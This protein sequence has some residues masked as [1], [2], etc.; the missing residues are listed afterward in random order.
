LGKPSEI[1]KKTTNK[2]TKVKE[3]PLPPK[4]TNQE[5]KVKKVEESKEDKRKKSSLYVKTGN[6]SQH[7]STKI[8]KHY[9]KSNNST[10]INQQK[11]NQ[12][13]HLTEPYDSTRTHKLL[14][15]PGNEGKLRSLF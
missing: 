2:I 13:I 15:G 1:V 12:A 3:F 10:K 4:A 7:N 14:E 11:I 5:K 8:I 6:A 9:K